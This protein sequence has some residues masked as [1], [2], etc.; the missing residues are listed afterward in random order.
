LPRDGAVLVLDLETAL[1]DVDDHG[2]ELHLDPELLQV[3]L[4]LLAQLRAERRQH[5]R[6]RVEQDHARLTGVDPAEVLLQRAVGELCDLAGHLDPGGAGPDDDEGQQPLDLLLVLGELGQLERA[7]DAAAQLERVVDALHA[8]RELGEAV[9]AEV[10]LAGTGGH[11]QRVVRRDG[12]AVQHARRDQ[13][14]LEVDAGDLA[15]DHARI[16]LRRED[17]TGRGRDL[18]LGQDAGGHL[19]E[20]RLEQVVGR[21]GDHRHVDIGAP[22]GLGAEET[23][24]TGADHDDLVPAGVLDDRLV[25]GGHGSP[26]TASVV[27]SRPL[28]VSTPSLP[29]LMHAQGMARLT[30][31]QAGWTG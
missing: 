16:L 8:G 31:R 18:A 19:V 28:P 12:H 27:H 4:G 6:R 22:Q 23:S 10:G 30:L 17:L 5:L 13:P 7:E 3:G 21:L 1:V 25:R 9:V 14:L 2:A 24:E 20:Q 26:F 15:E 29:R 11:D